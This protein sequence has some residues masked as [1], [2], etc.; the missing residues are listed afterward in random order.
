MSNKAGW[1]A[2]QLGAQV[3]V[4]Y[5]DYRE[6][7]RYPDGGCNAE[8]YTQR[9]FLEIES[10]GPLELLAPGAALCHSEQWQIWDLGADMFSKDETALTELGGRGAGRC[11]SRSATRLPFC[12]RESRAAGIKRIPASLFRTQQFGL[13]RSSLPRLP[14]ADT[15]CRIQI[16]LGESF[17]ISFRVARRSAHRGRT[18]TAASTA[19]L[20]AVHIIGDL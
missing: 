19:L 16:D 8:Y 15:G 3:F 20:D 5:H 2:Y 9:G 18:R 14:G 12:W 7:L 17:Q 13:Q 6:G 1:A 10:L 4:K 11:H